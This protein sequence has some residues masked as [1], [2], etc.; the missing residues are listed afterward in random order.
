MM[1]DWVAGCEKFI[2]GLRKFF[3]GGVEVYY[4]A[5]AV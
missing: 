5:G 4:E 3:A 2:A 1:D